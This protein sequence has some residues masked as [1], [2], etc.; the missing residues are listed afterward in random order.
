MANETTSPGYKAFERFMATEAPFPVTNG[1]YTL[2]DLRYAFI[3][4]RC[5]MSEEVLMESLAALRQ[6]LRIQEVQ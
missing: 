1:T 5:S 3:A 2:S 4:G 6:P